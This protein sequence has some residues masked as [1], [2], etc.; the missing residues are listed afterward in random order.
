MV[1]Y[2]PIDAWRSKNLADYQTG[3]GRMV[4][5]SDL[6]LPSTHVKLPCGQCIGCRLARARTWA[7]R[8]LHEAKFHEDNCFLTLTYNSD[9][10]PANG[11]LR[12]KDMVDFFK[13]LR[14]N[15]GQ[16]IRYFQCGEY[17][18]D[19]ARPHHHCIIFGYKPSDLVLFCDSRDNPLF[20]SA[21]LEKTWGHGFVTVGDVSFDSCCYTA[22]YIMKKVTGK[23]ADSVYAGL[24]PEYVTMSRRPGI[25]RFF[26]DK[27]KDDLYNHDVCV[28]REGFKAKPPKYYDN[29]YDVD[30]PE[31]MKLLKNK[32]KLAA[33]L[34]P[35]LDYKRQEALDE[36][37][38]LKL[39]QVPRKYEEGK[40]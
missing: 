2:H 26:Y 39:K 10:L 31:H 33:A 37:Q 23:H 17:G 6:G 14:K 15:T 8:C 30:N 22:R 29:L 21:S 28:V 40:L 36:C 24:L 19:Y 11:S 1:C 5:K 25:G 4:F 38:R 27:Y 34:K 20:Y 7:I 12:P 18:D 13:R 16:K 9:N 32:R 3:K 35:E